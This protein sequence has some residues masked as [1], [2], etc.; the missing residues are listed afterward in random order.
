M[1]LSENRYP[2]FRDHALEIVARI[3]TVER[4]VAE[5]NVRDDVV[6]D[7]GFQ[8]RPLKPGRIAHVASF[9]QAVA[10]AQPDQ[11]VAAESLHDRHALAHFPSKWDFFAY[12]AFGKPAQDLL[13]QRQALLD[14]AHP[15][16][17]PRIDVALAENRHLETQAV[18]GRIGQRLACI[19]RAARGAAD[20]AAGGILLG[21]RLPER[22][23]IDGTI[24]Q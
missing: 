12:R 22:S 14:F 8:Q 3:G 15:D 7:H 6:L 16:P 11:N 1:I 4:L 9:D 20:I 18:V 10:Q 17:D 13:D 24:L 21:E 2:L 5:W 19:E 23:G